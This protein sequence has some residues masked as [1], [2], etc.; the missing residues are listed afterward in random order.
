MTLTG[1]SPKCSFALSTTAGPQRSVTRSIQQRDNFRVDFLSWG[2]ADGS[3][4][5]LIQ[6]YATSI[7]RADTTLAESIWS[8]APEVTF[9]HPLGEEHG[10]AQIEEDVY[11]H[12]MGSTF[13]E[14]KLVPKDVSVHIYG[15]TAWSEFQWDFYAKVKKDGSAFHSQRRETQ[16]YRRENG[17][18]R[19]VHVHYSGMPVSGKLTGF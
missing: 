7:D 19:I 5:N 15:D 13:S 8:D 11:R 1:C 12:L 18:W 9:I 2:F 17:R 3:T 6:T 16:I 4:G 14:R 10:W